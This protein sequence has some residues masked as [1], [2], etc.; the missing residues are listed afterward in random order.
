VTHRLILVA[1]LA[2]AFLAGTAPAHAQRG[3]RRGPAMTP[4]GP[5]YNPTMSPDYRLYASNPA[6]YEQMMMNR[7]IQSANKQQ[8]A[9]QKQ[10]EQFQKWL[11]DQKAKKEKGKPTDPAYDQL[12]KYQEAQAQAEL[13]TSA[14]KNAK[15][16]PAKSL[17]TKKA[18]APKVAGAD[19][20]AATAKTDSNA[21]T[22]PKTKV[23]PTQDP[24]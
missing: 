7:Q 20:A 9:A 4:Y 19:D 18:G 24:E 17:K 21:K 15:R 10:Q 22:E 2:T 12:L 16:T 23:A 13:K 11:K 14:R 1:T 8:Q 5:V 6:A 3:Y